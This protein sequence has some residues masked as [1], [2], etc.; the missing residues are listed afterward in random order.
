M[1]AS[2]YPVYSHELAAH[3]ARQLPGRPIIYRLSA[4]AKDGYSVT[5]PSAG[6]EAARTHISSLE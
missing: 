1:A 5:V 4:D 2:D 3:Y 6:G